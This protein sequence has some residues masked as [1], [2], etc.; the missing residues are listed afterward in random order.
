MYLHIEIFLLLKVLVVANKKW[1]CFFK[2][3][4]PIKKAENTQQSFTAQNSVI[5]LCPSITSDH[6]DLVPNSMLLFQIWTPYFKELAECTTT[7]PLYYLK[8]TEIM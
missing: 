2:Y 4:S 7:A 3:K 1:L 6:S 8:D 5:L